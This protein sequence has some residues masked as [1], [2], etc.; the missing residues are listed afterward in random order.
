MERI[1]NI[2]VDGSV[3]PVPVLTGEFVEVWQRNSG[4]PPASSGIFRTRRGNV[5]VLYVDMGMPVTRYFV[6]GEN[7]ED[8]VHYPGLG[9]G[10]WLRLT[11][12]ARERGHVVCSDC[13][14]EYDEASNRYC[15]VCCPPGCV[16]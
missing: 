2:Y 6:S 14:L 7:L 13:L 9:E 5:G 3:A 8:D 10:K 12:E 15:P 11:L 1:Y 16:E 4:N